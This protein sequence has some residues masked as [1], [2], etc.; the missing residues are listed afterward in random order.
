MTFLCSA[1]LG[2]HPSSHLC[3]CRVW[4]PKRVAMTTYMC[5]VLVTAGREQLYAIGLCVDWSSGSLVAPTTIEQ[6]VSVLQLNNNSKSEFLL[7]WAEFIT[8]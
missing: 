7:F 8:N 1:C 4:L 2:L 6:W 5:A 3:F